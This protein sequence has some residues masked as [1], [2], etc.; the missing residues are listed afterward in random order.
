MKLRQTLEDLITTPVT[1]YVKKV[2]NKSIPNRKKCKETKQSKL[3]YFIT[4]YYN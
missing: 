3:N 1:H 2:A 4:G